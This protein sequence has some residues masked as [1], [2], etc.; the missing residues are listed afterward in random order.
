M[1]N[2]KRFDGRKTSSERGYGYKWQKARDGFL[3][4]HPLCVDHER[5]GYV[6]PAAVVDHIVPHRGDM[7]LFW[8]SN[9]WQALCKQCHDSYKQRLEKSGIDAGCDANGLPID[10]NH[11]WNK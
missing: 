3:R 8:D 6:E 10:R 2:S 1:P 4:K 5:R 9:N 11:H 7:G